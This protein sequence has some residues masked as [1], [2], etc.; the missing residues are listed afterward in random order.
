MLFA[1]SLPLL[2]VEGAWLG[3]VQEEIGFFTRPISSG[4]QPSRGF[5]DLRNQGLSVFSKDYTSLSSIVLLQASHVF[6]AEEEKHSGCLLPRPD[7]F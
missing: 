5:A 4:Y 2:A 1:S 6:V 7:G 3:D